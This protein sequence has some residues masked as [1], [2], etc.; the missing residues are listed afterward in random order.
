MSLVVV[1]SGEVVALS[2]AVLDVV[3]L[4]AVALVVVLVVVEVEAV[5]VGGVVVTPEMWYAVGLV[6]VIVVVY[7]PTTVPKP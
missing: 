2:G 5:D 1:A 7:S 6:N 4:G 3:S